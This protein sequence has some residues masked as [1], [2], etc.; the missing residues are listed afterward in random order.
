MYAHQPHDNLCGSSSSIYTSQPVTSLIFL[1]GNVSNKTKLM[2]CAF[3]MIRIYHVVIRSWNAQF[4]NIEYEN[5]TKFRRTARTSTNLIIVSYDLLIK[6]NSPSENDNDKRIRIIQR[7]FFVSQCTGE[8]VPPE[9]LPEKH[10]SRFF[11]L[12]NNQDMSRR[13]DD[14]TSIAICR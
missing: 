3:Q 9:S 2:T 5:V 12:K 13:Q 1:N 14:C 6:I 10:T 8:T 7:A 4:T 11:F